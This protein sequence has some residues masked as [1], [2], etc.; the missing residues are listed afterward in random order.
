MQNIH[1]QMI[2]KHFK[3]L[4]LNKIYLS[5]SLSYRYVNKTN[6]IIENLSK[7]TLAKERKETAIDL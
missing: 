4:F 1:K 7:A 2:E 5:L 3:M 6:I